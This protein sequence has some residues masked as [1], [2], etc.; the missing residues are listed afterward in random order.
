MTG[1]GHLTRSPRRGCL[2]GMH[3]EKRRGWFTSILRNVCQLR[4]HLA[5]EIR[6][7]ALDGGQ[8]PPDLAPLAAK[9]RQN[10]WKVT[11]DDIAAAKRAGYS[12]DQLFELTVATALGAS[13]QRLDVVLGALQ[14]ED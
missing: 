3:R 5:P 11:D 4:G 1:Q 2:G 6:Q 8:L 7:A 10:A 9:I 14:R 12:E 13:R